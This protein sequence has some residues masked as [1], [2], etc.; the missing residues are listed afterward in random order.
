MVEKKEVKSEKKVALMTWFHYENYGTALQCSA[1]YHTIKKRGYLIDLIDYYPKK[2]AVKDDVNP[3]LFYFTKKAFSRVYHRLKN[4]RPYTSK[5]KT[6]LFEGYLA[7]R[8]TKTKQVKTA[9]ELADFNGDYDAFVCGSDQIWAPICF[10]DKYYLSFVQNPDKMV[11]YA[12]SMGVMSISN[13]RIR[14]KIKALLNRFEHLAIRETQGANIIKDLTGKTAKVVLDPTLLLSNAEWDEFASV[15]KTNQIEGKYILCYFLGDY[16][17]TLKKV[18]RFAKEKHL[19]YYYIPVSENMRGYK[20]CVPFDVGPSEFVSLIKGA[21]YMLT[22]SFHG[23]AFSVNYK[24]QVKV[25]KRFTKKDPRNQNSRIFSLMQLLGIEGCCVDEKNIQKSYHYEIDYAPVHKRLEELKA[26]SFSYLENALAKATTSQKQ[27]SKNVSEVLCCGCGGCVAVCPFGAIS[28][29]MDEE[30]FYHSVID[31]EKCTHCGKCQKVCPMMRVQTQEIKDSQ[32]L[33]SIK[34][35]SEDTLKKSSSGGISHELSKH[36]IEK[37]Y[38]VFGCTYDESRNGAKHIAIE[39]IEDL[40]KIQGSKYIQSDTSLVMEQ[41][42]KMKKGEKAVFF[43]T[44][45]QVAGVDKLLLQANRREDFILVDLICHGVP[46]DYLWKKYLAD[47]DR[48]YH[49]GKNPSVVFRNKKYAWR[50]MHITLCGNHHAYA[51]SE[52]KDDFYAFFCNC[53]C[54]M[55]T[56]YECPY[57]EKSSADLRIG[58]Y[59]GDRY[60]KDKQGV[61]MVIAATKRGEEALSILQNVCRVEGG[62]LAEYWSVQVPYNISPTNFREDMI[63]DFQKDDVSLAQT[64]KKYC[65]YYDSTKKL[66]KIY[67]SL[68]SILKIKR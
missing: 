30:G 16:K 21:E 37:G 40:Y 66:L 47:A 64:R 41:I 7:D 20:H 8:I 24:K 39:N 1:L 51:K 23:L 3:S 54:Y 19:P 28:M 49:I 31:S 63:C 38:T 56:C 15:D 44:P 67:G 12:P 25:F 46:S 17:K 55:K 36:F 6:A 65:R 14:E 53:L 9:V 50:E 4:H 11:A 27:D 58:D 10:D 2:I 34:S 59:W 48:K 68:R 61:S 35:K 29:Q 18:Q 42:A 57:R 62:N 26:E 13:E 43:G 33:Y 45:C 60:K 5:G 22:D 52:K 32:G